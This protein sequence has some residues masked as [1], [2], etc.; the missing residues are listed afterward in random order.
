MIGIKQESHRNGEV[1]SL[2]VDTT[3][4][5]AGEEAHGV[6][7]EGS[8]WGKPQQQGGWEMR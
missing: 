1:S 3:K 4:Y 2:S 6:H 8:F 5:V 7:S